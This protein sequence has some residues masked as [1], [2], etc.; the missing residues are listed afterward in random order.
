MY[1][2]KR[3]KNIILVLQV[4]RIRKE[5]CKQKESCEQNLSRKLEKLKGKEIAISSI[6]QEYWE[7]TRTIPFI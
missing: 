6:D 5:N 7:N 2:Q 3:D 1:A 4:Q